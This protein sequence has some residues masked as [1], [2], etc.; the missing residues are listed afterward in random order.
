MHK[1][2]FKPWIVQIYIIRPTPFEDKQRK[3]GVGR[4]T[5]SLNKSEETS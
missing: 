5:L 4:G 3:W 2:S 1:I